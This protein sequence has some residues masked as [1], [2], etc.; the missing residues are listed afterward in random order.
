MYGKELTAIRNRIKVGLREKLKFDQT[1]GG[2][3]GVSHVG[4]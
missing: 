2:D 4:I 1:G 3:K